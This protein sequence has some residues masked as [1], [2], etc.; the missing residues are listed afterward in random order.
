MK[1]L[2]LTLVLGASVLYLSTDV[3]AQIESA[4]VD[5]QYYKVTSQFAIWD[6]TDYEFLPDSTCIK[7][8][9]DQSILCGTFLIVPLPNDVWVKTRVLKNN[10][11]SSS[12]DRKNPL[13]TKIVDI[14][15][16]DEIIPI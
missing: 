11:Q 16:E 10:V 4:S 3:S 6:V 15:K 12:V 14:V 7:I 2:I 8:S 9:V 1:Y 5:K 13:T